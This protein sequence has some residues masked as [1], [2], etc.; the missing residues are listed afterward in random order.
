[1]ALGP[2][3]MNG[4]LQRTQDISIIKQNEDNRGLLVQ[5]NIQ[6]EAEQE[7]DHAMHQVHDADNSR[8]SE[9]EFDARREGRNKYMKT[10]TKKKKEPKT[11]GKVVV[12]GRGGFD[13]SV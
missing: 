3:E 13:I 6:N 2:V 1:M 11:E 4:I 10:T 9:G 7:I 12:K 8:D 5:T